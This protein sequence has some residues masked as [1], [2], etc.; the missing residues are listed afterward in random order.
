MRFIFILTVAAVVGLGPFHCT[1]AQTASYP[2]RPV[3]I[4]VPLTP[5]GGVD[6][7]AR[8]VADHLSNVLGQ[9]VVVDNRPGAGGSIGVELVAGAAKD[10]HTLLVSSSSLV[11][12]AAVQQQR[13]DPIRDFTPITKL[14]SNPYL[15]VVNPTLAANSVQELVA[16]AK[17]KRGAL[18]YASSGTG[19]VLHLGSEL[20]CAIAGVRMTHIPFKG[21]ADAYPAVVA[22]DVSWILGSPI[23]A[24][25]LIRAGRMKALAVTTAMRSK[26]MPEL[27]TIAE[28]GVAGYDVTAWFG[29]FAPSGVPQSVVAR[30]HE[31]SSKAIRAPE[32][33]RRLAAEG[34]DVVGN[35]PREFAAEVK[36]EFEKWRALAKT[37]ELKL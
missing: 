16:L 31:E 12:N 2:Q 6:S 23:S 29:M 28:S 13:Y 5:G 24:L 33:A 19:G 3:R 25:P 21:V 34:T 14:T 22:G 32:L 4:V 26:A 15:L 36:A 27:P 7:A 18:T 11:T 10:G 8:I 30:L 35:T 1:A 17:A 9:R 37:T 20:L